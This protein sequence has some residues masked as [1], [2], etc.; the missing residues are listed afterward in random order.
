MS[1]QGQGTKAL[2]ILC[3]VSGMGVA[4]C[5]RRVP[6]QEGAGW[7]NV[8]LSVRTE[9][10]GNQSL[11]VEPVAVGPAGAGFEVVYEPAPLI[12]SVVEELTVD[13]REWPRV[14]RSEQ[15]ATS[16]VS[17]SPDMLEV[18]IFFE[19]G[20]PSIGLVHLEIRIGDETFVFEWRI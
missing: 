12:G 2:V 1:S 19:N 8:A 16:D 6:P 7:P 10:K 20:G 18:S 15:Q 4:S 3:I 14:P 13:G 9:Q 5:S 17:E 11:T